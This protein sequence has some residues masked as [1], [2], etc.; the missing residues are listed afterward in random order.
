M[1]IRLPVVVMCLAG[2]VVCCRAA[3]VNIAGVQE[4]L[5]TARIAD[6][7]CTAQSDQIGRSRCFEKIRGEQLACLDRALA[8]PSALSAKSTSE[9]PAVV[10]TPESHSEDVVK[11][12]DAPHSPDV[13]TGSIPA[14]GSDSAPDAVRRA[15]PAPPDVSTGSVPAVVLNGAPDV[16][17]KAEFP[18]PDVSKGRLPA[19]AADDAPGAARKADPP[20]GEAT[21]AA[22]APNQRAETPAPPAANWIMSETTSPIDYSPLLTAAIR[23]RSEVKD[24]PNTLFVRCRRQQTELSVHTDGAWAA[25]RGNDIHVEYRI[26]GQPGDKVRWIIS[27]DGKT[28]T[29]GADPVALLQSWPDGAT[30]ALEV[31]GAS[32]TRHEATFKLAGLDAIRKRIGAACHW[33]SVGISAEIDDLIPGTTRKGGHRRPPRQTP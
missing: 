13:S 9:P 18:P 24:G 6:A 32:G 27:P 14:V 22:A 19:A 26:D 7:A 20:P 11:P 5:E 12:T 16:V 8:D 21:A 3:D 2:G 23:A 15:E 17:R 10:A 31:A 30:L 33:T 25:P 29:Y 4:C 28:A 1:R